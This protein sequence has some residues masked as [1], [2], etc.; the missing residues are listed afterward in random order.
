MALREEGIEAFPLKGPVLSQQ[1]YGSIHERHSSDIDLLV[2]NPDITRMIALFEGLG[3]ELKYPKKGLPERQWRYY[4]RYKKDIGFF[5]REHGMFLELHFHIEN[6]MGLD[7][8]Y[9]EQ[10]TRHPEEIIIGGM[11][12]KTLNKHQAF[13]YLSLH[14]AVHQYRRLFWLRDIAVAIRL[15]EPDH[16][17]IVEEAKAMGIER[18]VCVSVDLARELFNIEVPTAYI[19]CLEENRKSIDKLKQFSL[20]VILGTEFPTLKGKIGHHLFMLRSKPEIKHYFR[21][22]GE[23]LNRYCIGRF[24]GGH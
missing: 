9:P 5:S 2:L 13:L 20:G 24:L 1:L 8:S 18:M 7:A 16:L 10:L 21:T 14:G 22:A 11:S 12:F 4:L 6:Y 15:W 23:I 17:K 19:S 3:F